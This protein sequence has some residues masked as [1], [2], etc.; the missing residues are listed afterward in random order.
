MGKQYNMIHWHDPINRVAASRNRMVISS[1]CKAISDT[2]KKDV[3]DT[4][5][6][7]LKDL[8]E[9]RKQ[10]QKLYEYWTS[11]RFRSC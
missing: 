11:R 1:L 8:R 10:P 7:M 9:F 5:Q 6:S 2:R 4:R 3:A